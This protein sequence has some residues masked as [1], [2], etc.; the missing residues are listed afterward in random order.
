M[1]LVHGATLQEV[2]PS[3]LPDIIRIFRQLA[4]AVAYVHG[5][6]ILHCDIRPD[7]VLIS[8]DGVVKLIDFGE[9]IEKGQQ[10]SKPRGL[11]AFVSPEALLERAVDER[12]DVYSFGTLLYWTLTGKYL[13]TN[14]ER[15]Q[16]MMEAELTGL[17]AGLRSLIADCIRLEVTKRTS[18][19][20]DVLS[21]LDI[22]AERVEQ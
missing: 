22:I 18:A 19:M 13:P 11:P 3:K 8:K 1:E 9:A 7:N 14:P 6:G 10:K 15:R 2:K 5:E 21:R 16:D 12:T 17:P 20:Y 4:Q